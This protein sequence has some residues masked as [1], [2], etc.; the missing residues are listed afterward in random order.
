VSRARHRGEVPRI[1]RSARCGVAIADALRGRLDAAAPT[2]CLLISARRSSQLTRSGPSSARQIGDS[3]RRSVRSRTSSPLRHV[4]HDAARGAYPTGVATH[5]LTNDHASVSR[6]LR[7]VSGRLVEQSG[8]FKMSLSE[9]RRREPVRLCP[10]SGLE[11]HRRAV[12]VHGIADVDP[13]RRQ[14]RGHWPR[15]DRCHRGG[16]GDA[17]L[18]DIAGRGVRSRAS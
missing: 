8:K 7:K 3:S 18:P 2:G 5:D 15:A 1:A 14:P 6:E 13:P 12:V 16:N 9:V 17:R 11:L 4:A 10:A